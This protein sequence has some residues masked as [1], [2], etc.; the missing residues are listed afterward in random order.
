M[1]TRTERARPLSL[2]DRRAAIIDAVIPL[3]MEHGRA[4]STR[5]IAD[6]AGIAEG[7]IFRAFPDKDALIDAAVVKYLDPTTLNETLRAIDRELPLEQ[8]IDALLVHLRARMTGMF[9]IMNAVGMR[10][11][12]PGRPDPGVFYR[13]VETVLGPDLEDLNVPVER[14]AQILRLVAFASTVPHFSEGQSMPAAELARIITY[15]IAGHAAGKKND[16]AA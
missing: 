2:E 3:L 10:G 8:K 5:E 15:G 1:P 4:V 6:A 12:P 14:A 9:G 7:T 11:R 13:L 16:D